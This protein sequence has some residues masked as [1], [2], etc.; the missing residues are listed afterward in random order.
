MKKILLGSS[1]KK[2]LKE[3]QNLLTDTP[4]DIVTAK[5]MNITLPDVIEDGST[6]EEN[7]AKKAIAFSKFSGLPAIADD[8]GL[9]VDALNGQP[10]LYSARWSGEHGERQTEAN[11]HKL[12]TELSGVSKEQR[13]AK[14]VCV[15]VMAIADEVTITTRGECPGL[16]IEQLQGE[17]GFGYDPLF[18]IPQYNKTFAQLGD[19]KKTIS[20]RAIALQ[21]FREALQKMKL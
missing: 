17:G 12:L 1:N 20:H 2:K 18:L 11:N 7:A 14:F 16:I 5:D 3:L 9:E 13:T 19:I 6:Y 21:R 10:G 4:F 15:I 8:S